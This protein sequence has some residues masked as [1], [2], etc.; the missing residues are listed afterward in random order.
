MRAVGA[1]VCVSGLNADPHVRHCDISECENVGL[2]ITDFAQVSS[3]VPRPST[4]RRV[5]YHLML[6][7][8]TGS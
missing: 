5:Q 8:V 1:A 7:S 3:W 4:P 2:Y 6:V